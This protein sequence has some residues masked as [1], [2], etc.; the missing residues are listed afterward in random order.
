LGTSSPN[1]TVPF[2]GLFLTAV[3]QSVGAGC[4]EG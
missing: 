4:W 1:I 3:T 2:A